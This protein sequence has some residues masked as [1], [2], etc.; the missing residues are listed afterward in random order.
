MKNWFKPITQDKKL[1]IFDKIYVIIIQSK[2]K[3]TNINQ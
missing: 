1:L 2:K 3:L